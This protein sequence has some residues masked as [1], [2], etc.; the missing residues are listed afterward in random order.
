MCVKLQKAVVDIVTKKKVL[1]LSRITLVYCQFHK[2]RIFICFVHCC[3]PN[4]RDR[5][6]LL[7]AG[8]PKLF[9]LNE[10]MPCLETFKF[11]Y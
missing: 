5:Y 1:V 6:A 11:K 2:V 9:L 3:T 10:Y 4:T 7:V 8:T